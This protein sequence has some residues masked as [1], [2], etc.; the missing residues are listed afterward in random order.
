MKIGIENI[1]Y[2]NTILLNFIKFRIHRIIFKCI[3]KNIALGS[4]RNVMPI[5]IK[6]FVMI[7]VDDNH[8]YRI[9]L[10]YFKPRVRTTPMP[11]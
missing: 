2:Y 9:I 8:T 1:K 5:F 10:V 7:K 4:F 3:D 11:M 6:I